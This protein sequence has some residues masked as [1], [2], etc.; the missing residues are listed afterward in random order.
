MLKIWGRRNSINVQKVLWTAEFCSLPY[1][2]IE[3][4]GAFGGREDMS[5]QIVLAL[6]AGRL[7]RPVRI[8]WTRRESIIGHDQ[9]A[10]HAQA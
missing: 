5:V 8:I 3:V 7:Q 10:V 9:W 1:D 4:G 6:A 2:S